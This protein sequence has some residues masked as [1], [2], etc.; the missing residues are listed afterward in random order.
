M[1]QENRTGLAQF[2]VGEGACLNAE[3][4]TKGRP[5]EVL[6]ALGRIREYDDYELLRKEIIGGTITRDS[7][8]RL[9]AATTGAANQEAT[10]STMEEVSRV[11]FRLQSLYRPV[12]A[13]AQKGLWI[14]AIIGIAIKAVDTATVFAAI[15]GP[16]LF[17]W[18]L[19]G[20]AIA[21][22]SFTSK[23]WMVAAGTAYFSF[24]YGINVFGFLGAWF[25]TALIG[26]LYGGLIGM[27]VGTLVG[28]IRKRSLE[29][30]EDALVEGRKPLIKGM[31]IP[32][33]VIA[34][35][36]P[37]HVLWLNPLLIQWLSS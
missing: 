37:L 11:H 33:A 31:V 19:V 26:G 23:G 5:I 36:A 13:H 9:K 20:G 15:G 16:A 3:R 17:L 32:M 2:T 28:Y 27:A 22:M 10:W 35:I 14:G 21:A 7:K 12:W 25:S 30:A 8:A 1:T 18:L 29:Q 4:E 34:V 24:K 6:S